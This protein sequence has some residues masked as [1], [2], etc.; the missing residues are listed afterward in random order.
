MNFICKYKFWFSIVFFMGLFTFMW[1]I[2]L[3]MNNLLIFL[4][5]EILSLNSVGVYMTLLIDWMSMIFLGCVLFISS[6]VI[7]YSSSYMMNDIYKL[8]FLYIVLLFVMSMFLLIISPNLISILLGW[9]G[10]GLVSYCLVIYFQN[11]KSYNAGMLTVLTNRIGDVAILISIAWF[12][13]FGSWNYIYY[14]YLTCNFYSW[15][16]F[17]MVVAAFTKSAQI[18]FSSWLPAAMAAP[19]PVSALVHSS[20]LVTAGVYLL[21]RFSDFILSYDVSIFLLL[22][23]LTMF[24]SGLG[25]NFE[26]DLKKI[27]A[28]STLSQLGLMMSSLFMGFPILAYFH[29]LSHAFFKA[30]LFLCAGLM[31]HCMSDSQD[32]RHMGYMINFMPYTC[33]CFCISNLSLCGL[34]FLSGFYSKDLILESMSM[35]YFNLFIYL[36]FYVS[37]GL[38]ACYSFRLIYYCVTNN[39]GL[40]PFQSFFEDLNMNIS[41]I[42]LTFMAISCGSILSWLLTPCPL[43]LVFSL[44]C[45]LM[46][47][48]F[49]SLGGWLGYESSCLLTGEGILGLTSNF[50]V[51][52]LSNMWFMPNFSTYMMY[53]DTLFLSKSLNLFMDSGWGEYIMSSSMSIFSNYISTFMTNYQF[54][55][56]K[57]FLLTFLFVSLFLLFL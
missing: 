45:K 33:S 24:M 39:S 4:D 44:E 36:I 56:I 8:R 38:T 47:L 42:F 46:P 2:Y 5:W 57:L 18:P 6:M 29:L 35:D 30:L 49:V 37:V 7:Y 25:A 21:I 12:I 11:Y 41:M 43:L 10:L 3:L 16:L 27:I 48:L 34:P 19:T 20:T 55:S 17:L 50:F 28:L 51:N 15:I 1:G 13:N 26:Y 9:D 40:F 53:S 54:N 31:I 32:I 22:S 52:F 23:V 14:L